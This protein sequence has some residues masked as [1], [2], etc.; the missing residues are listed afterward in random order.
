M[1][2]CD[3]SLLKDTMV[4]MSYLLEYYINKKGMVK[5]SV[6]AVQIRRSKAEAESK[7]ER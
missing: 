7:K 2:G 6:S 5:E 3:G 1:K 4:Q